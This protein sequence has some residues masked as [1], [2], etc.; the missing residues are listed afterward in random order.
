MKNGY[1]YFLCSLLVC[2]SLSASMPSAPE[3]DVAQEKKTVFL[4]GAA[5]FIGS[6]FLQ[7]MFDK[8]PSYHFI[9]LDALTYA[10]NLESIPQTIKNSNRFE[11]IHGSITDQL[12]V[13]RCMAQADFVV[14][15]AAE[16]HVTRDITRSLE[17]PQIFVQANCVGV[18]TL[19]LSLV[20]CKNVQRFIHISTSEVYGTAETEPMTEDHP[21][22][23]RTPYAATKAAG[24][25]L[26][27]SYCCCYDIPAVIVRPFNNYGPFQHPEKV[28]PR[29]ITNALS[30]LPITIHGDGNAKRDW[31]HVLDTC[32]A[33]DLMLHKQDFSTIKNEV[34]NLGTG[35][36]ASV[37]DIAMHIKNYCSLPDSAITYQ[38][39]RPGQVAVHISSIDKAY[40]L[41]GWKA[42]HTLADSINNLIEW[43][44]ENRSWWTFQEY[45]PCIEIGSQGNK[46]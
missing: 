23:P 21:L 19:M 33:L 44:K 40:K 27:Y 42:E 41:L 24:D 4:T 17:S 32:K 26:V 15:F 34:I 43:Y 14:N 9:V 1:H 25:R 6:N 31:L 5:G 36:S 20:K 7:Y 45:M 18:V 46:Y 37:Y 8:Y 3:A 38:P 30:G 12:T 10:G 28:I 13:D 35:Q 2:S 11:F 39:D 29:F 22:N 16:S